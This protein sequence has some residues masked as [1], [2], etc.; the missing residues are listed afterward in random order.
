VAK[1]G[2]QPAPPLVAVTAETM[3]R[4]PQVCR[5]LV[6]GHSTGEIY[7]LARNEWQISTR[8]TDRLVAH[9]RAELERAWDLERPALVAL[10]LTRCDL[11]FRMAVEQNNSGAAIA[12]ISTA[13]RLAKL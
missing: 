4:V 6:R 1:H 13:A 8:Q 7:E 10:L 3:A 9:A 5:W 12:A 2:D 11:V